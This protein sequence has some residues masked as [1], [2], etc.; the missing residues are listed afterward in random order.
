MACNCFMEK[1]C[2]SRMVK[3]Q[4]INVTRQLFTIKCVKELLKIFLGIR[5]FI[6]E[7][8]K[9]KCHSINTISIY[10]FLWTQSIWVYSEAH[11]ILFLN[12]PCTFRIDNNPY[13]TI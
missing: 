8:I 2:Y 10:T 5:E 11:K 1:C 12:N 4:R 7:L 3:N 9:C 13:F 6:D